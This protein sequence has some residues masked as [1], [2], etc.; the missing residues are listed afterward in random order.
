MIQI[1]IK[2]GE[3]AFSL[4]AEGHSL[5]DV[6][7]K[8]IVC[9]AVSILIENFIL[10]ENELCH[11]DLVLEKTSGKVSLSLNGYSADDKLLFRSLL[12]GLIKLEQQYKGNINLIWE[13][14]HGG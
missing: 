6:R 9:A 2:V 12:L 7:G 11:Q 1:N 14:D 3:K 8:D 5:F 13:E 10:S 4:L